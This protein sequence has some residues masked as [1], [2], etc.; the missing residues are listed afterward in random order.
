M[1]TPESYE[2]EKIKKYLRSIGAWFFL[3]Y[4]AGFGK[5]GV[6]DIIA[7]IDGV[8]WAIEVKRE[9]KEPTKRQEL[10]MQE[11]RAAGGWATAG[12]AKKVIATIEDW[13]GP[14]T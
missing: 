10:R 8:F 9:G 1:R 12:T 14:Q 11:V 6:S 4:M 7:C 2:K 5:G 3:P 13:H